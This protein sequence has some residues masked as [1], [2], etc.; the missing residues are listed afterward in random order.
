MSPRA[1]QCTM[2]QPRKGQRPRKNANASSLHKRHKQPLHSAPIRLTAGWA[3][4]ELTIRGALECVRGELVQFWF[5][6][7]GEKAVLHPGEYPEIFAK[8]LLCGGNAGR[9]EGGEV[10]VDH[11]PRLQL[12]HVLPKEW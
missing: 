5:S 6:L 1:A 10:P 8:S 4:I 3:L 2:A 12:E 7:G 9:S 11:L